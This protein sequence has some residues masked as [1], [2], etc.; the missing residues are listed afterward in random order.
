[1]LVEQ[2][3]SYNTGIK[4]LLP[5]ISA[6]AL[7]LP[8]PSESSLIMVDMDPTQFL[9]RNSSVAALVDTEAYALGSRAFD[10]IALEYILDQRKASALARGY[11]RILSVPDLTLV[12]PVYRYFYRLLEI[13]EKSEIAIWQAQPLLFEPSP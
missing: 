3:H 5:A 7:R 4:E 1:M 12:R 8:E 11:S 2:Y 13:Q 6:E 10:F 9:V